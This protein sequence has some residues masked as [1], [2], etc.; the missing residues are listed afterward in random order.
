[1]KQLLFFESNAKC[2]I[3]RITILTVGGIA[4]KYINCNLVLLQ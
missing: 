3:I 4:A 1:M 2:H